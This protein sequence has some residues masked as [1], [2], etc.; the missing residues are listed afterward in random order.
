MINM[1]ENTENT[2][3]TENNENNEDENIL[4]NGYPRFILGSLNSFDE[5]GEILR[6]YQLMDVVFIWSNKN[7]LVKYDGIS[8]GWEFSCI[9]DEHKN[10]ED[11]LYYAENWLTIRKG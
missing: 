11:A 10:K 5:L 2:E 7:E 1:G 6:A 9:I 4:S 3:N 8:L